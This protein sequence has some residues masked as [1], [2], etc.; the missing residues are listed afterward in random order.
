M[1]WGQVISSPITQIVLTL[2][3]LLLVMFLLGFVADPIINLYVD[4]FDTLL[5]GGLLEEIP[6][7]RSTRERI[8]WTE[9]FTKGLAS[10]GVLSFLKV[11]LAMSPWHIW[12]LRSS[13]LI[14]GR[15]RRPAATGRDR[16]SSISW[17]VIAVGVVTFLVV[18]LFPFPN[19]SHVL[20]AR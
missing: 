13:G 8:T 17:I 15:A 5:S 6:L 1:K 16:A 2:A 7:S 12:N 18:R 10:L 20:D 9:H 19:A 14:G 4:P 11:I 3:V